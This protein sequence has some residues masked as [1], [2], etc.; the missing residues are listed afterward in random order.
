MQIEEDAGADELPETD[1]AV[2]VTADIAG[3][4]DLVTGEITVAATAA[5]D[6]DA[7]GI[8]ERFDQFDEDRVLI[9]VDLRTAQPN[10]MAS[11]IVLIL[12]KVYFQKK[13]VML[14]SNF[15]ECKQTK[16]ILCTA[17][18][19]IGDVILRHR[20]KLYLNMA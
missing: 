20:L 16:I 5:G 14:R 1:G 12:P 13:A 9:A 4:G 8:A 3:T 15:I 2:A 10:E 6:V 19:D 7:I 11:S 17:V 18:S